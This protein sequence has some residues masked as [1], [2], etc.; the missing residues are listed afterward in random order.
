[1]DRWTQSTQDPRPS[2]PPP[3]PEGRR[4]A[5]EPQ[6]GKARTPPATAPPSLFSCFP[7][8]PVELRLEIWRRA[9]AAWPA[10]DTA[11]GVCVLRGPSAVAGPGSSSSSSS[12]SGRNPRP[13]QWQPQ[14]MDAPVVRGAAAAWPRALRRACRESR[15]AA[16]AG[17]VPARPFDPARDM[18][19]VPSALLPRFVAHCTA[20]RGHRRRQEWQWRRRREGGGGGG[21]GHEAEENDAAGN[22]DEEE[23]D[24]M[25]Y[26]DDD[27]SLRSDAQPWVLDV[28][29]LAVAMCDAGA[30]L[31]LSLAA[32]SLHDLETVSVVY[33]ASC[34]TAW[35]VDARADVVETPGGSSANA[36]AAAA[37][38]ASGETPVLRR[39][40]PD[41]LERLQVR[42]DYLDAQRGRF[43]AVKSAWE[44][45][46]H[47]ERIQRNLIRR[48]VFE[49]VNR[50][51]PRWDPV[52]KELKLKYEARYFA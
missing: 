24:E 48:V 14:P 52:T 46:E 9:A 38:T 45:M 15:D 49:T 50:H 36:A 47:V 10:A 11:A 2:S 20:L 19:Y 29:R 5:P 1:M 31:W 8:L 33:P 6:T 51:P 22:D 28:R 40:A 3:H 13:S 32:S 35:E 4:P 27:V 21:G 43:S 39:L 42:A 12:S 7:D 23:E 25:A 18:L 41:E 26:Y 37:A 34:V 17:A 30:G 44:Y 16:R